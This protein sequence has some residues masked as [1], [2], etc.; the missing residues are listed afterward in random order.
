MDT[1]DKIGLLNEGLLAIGRKRHAQMDN[2]GN[3]DFD[4]LDAMSF[5]IKQE[6]IDEL[7]TSVFGEAYEAGSIVIRINF[8]TDSKCRK[9]HLSESKFFA[10]SVEVVHV[11]DPR[12]GM[13][14]SF[15]PYRLAMASENE[16]MYDVIVQNASNPRVLSGFTTIYAYILSLIDPAVDEQDYTASGFTEEAAGILANATEK[17]G[18]EENPNGQSQAEVQ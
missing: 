2:P 6:E 7:L 4:E 3:I 12:V 11:T 16:S 10:S 8:S 18:Q 13:K 17:K 1:V 15:M 5:C 14:F 9:K